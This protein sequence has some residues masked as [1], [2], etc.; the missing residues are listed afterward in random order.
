MIGPND[1]RDLVDW[2]K[3]TTDGTTVYELEYSVPVS[4]PTGRPRTLFGATSGGTVPAAEQSVR[5]PDGER[6]PATDV[7][8][9]AEGTTL[10]IR[11]EEPPLLARLWRALPWWTRG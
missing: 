8:F 9:E 7:T 6:I 11:V 4:E 2:R 10:R 3:T 1:D 5:L